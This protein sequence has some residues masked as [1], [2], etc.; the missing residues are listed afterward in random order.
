MAA[1]ARPAAGI[2]WVL[3]L[4]MVG[5]ASLG[6]QHVS[7]QTVQPRELLPRVAT[8]IQSFIDGF[9]NVVAEE[10]YQQE[11]RSPRRKRQ[12][13]SDLM[14]VKYPGADGWLVFR[15]TFEVDGKSVRSEPERLTRLFLE[16]PESRLS[17]AR[18]I[19]AAS[20]KYNLANIG[21]VNNP[22]LVHALMQGSNQPRFR[23][24]L[25]NIEKSLGPDVR[26]IQFQEYQTP[27]LIKVDG[28]ADIFFNGL[29]WVE[30]TTGRIV[31]TQFN[32]GRRGTGVEVI[33]TF[34]A[35][36]ELAIDVPATL[37][38]WY[39]D[40]FGG[41]ITGEATYSRFRRFQVTTAE[42]LKK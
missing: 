27:S 35:D 24:T 11:T 38:E 39:P 7:A 23:F 20:A 15:D 8:Y 22:L 9:S 42:D 5:P 13:K 34:R 29:M 14:L 25:G 17:R 4:L 36:P 21:T 31:K 28:N 33:T 30:Q 40:G 1:G 41:D 12:L 6:H 18:E 32:V 37:K 26:T 10:T 2:A 19:T 16:P 3:A